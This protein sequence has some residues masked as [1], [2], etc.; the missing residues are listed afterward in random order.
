MDHPVDLVG[1]GGQRMRPFGF[2]ITRLQV[3]RWWG[4]NEDV[5]LLFIPDQS[6]FYTRVPLVLG[7]CTLGQIINVS[8]E[9]EL[10]QLAIPWA[11][12]CLAQLLSQR[13]GV[14]EPLHEGAVGGKE[15]AHMEGIDDVVELK[16]SVCM[17]PFQME[18]LKGKVK[19]P[20]M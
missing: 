4:Y 12:I 6:A 18:I 8:K 9:S 14:E 5:V 15:D 11:A 10:D 1:I 19:K 20:P 16:D 7:T 3:K 17:G 2:L 13:G